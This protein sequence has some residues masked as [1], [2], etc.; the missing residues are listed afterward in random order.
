MVLS[1]LYG[2]TV[3]SIHGHWENH[4]FDETGL[5][6]QSVIYAFNTLSR[7]TI[8][9][10]WAITQSLCSL[11]TQNLAEFWPWESFQVTHVPCPVAPVNARLLCARQGAPGRQS[12][13]PPAL[14]PPPLGGSAPSLRE[15]LLPVPGRGYRVAFLAAQSSV[16]PRDMFSGQVSCGPDPPCYSEGPEMWQCA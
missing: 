16:C 9:L 15:P 14:W 13:L 11:L 3:T 2:P 6:Q 4:S 8:A 10:C 5:C 7:L 12:F 1:F